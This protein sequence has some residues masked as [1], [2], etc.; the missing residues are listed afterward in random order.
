MKK[1][2]KAVTVKL[3]KNNFKLVQKTAK[4]CGLRPNQVISLILECEVNIAY[5]A[6][7]KRLKLFKK[8]RIKPTAEKLFGI[9]ANFCA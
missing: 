5:Y 8:L 2:N 4:K 1:K 7:N 9:K 3:S 6:A